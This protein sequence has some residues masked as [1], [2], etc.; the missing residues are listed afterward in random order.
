MLPCVDLTAGPGGYC[1]IDGEIFATMTSR[2]IVHVAT[3]ESILE[4]EL[5]NFRPVN[6]VVPV[7]KYEL[8]GA[9]LATA[10]KNP[11]RI[12]GSSRAVVE[13]VMIV[14]DTPTAMGFAGLSGLLA[15]AGNV[16]IDPGTPWSDGTV[17]YSVRATPRKT[18]PSNT[19]TPRG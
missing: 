9:A 18:T 11:N 6:T 7:S 1:H 14:E 8:I 17:R 16:K 5:A 10:F 15:F 2:E 13:I 19:Q 4:I 12:T 3:N